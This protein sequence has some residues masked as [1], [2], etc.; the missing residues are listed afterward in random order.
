MPKKEPFHKRVILNLVISFIVNTA[1]ITGLSMLIPV[2]FLIL[3]PKGVVALTENNYKL[4]LVSLALI[5]ASAAVLFLRKKSPKKTLRDL[6]MM[7]LVPGSAALLFMLF[8]KETIAGI[9]RSYVI[10]AHEVDL[11][12]NY[13]D[14]TLPKLGILMVGYII[15]GAVFMYIGHRLRR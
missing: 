3:F 14:S 4:L 7:T 1:Y 11:I 2:I 10:N 8:G 6:G 15:I 13:V 12:I 9:L 5:A